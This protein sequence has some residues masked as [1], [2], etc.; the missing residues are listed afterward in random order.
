M[1]SKEA[2]KWLTAEFKHAGIKQPNGRPINAR[3]IARWRAE[4][5]GKSL[6]GS[7]EAFALLVLG[8]P[9]RLKK[10]YPLEQSDLPHTPQRAKSVAAVFIKLL[11][12]A[13]F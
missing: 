11:K 2:S 7:D 10:K 4:L 5:V 13:G 3:A 1:S 12:I 6:K 9:A 8:T